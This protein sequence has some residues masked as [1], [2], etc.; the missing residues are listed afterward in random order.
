MSPAL[1]LAFLYGGFTLSSPSAERGGSFPSSSSQ[2][3]KDASHWPG[4]GRM[5]PTQSQLLWHKGMDCSD[6]PGLLTCLSQQLWAEGSLSE[7]HG[8]NV[9]SLLLEGSQVGW[10]KET[11]WLVGAK[12]IGARHTAVCSQVLPE[13][14]E[15]R[16]TF[17]ASRESREKR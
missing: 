3:S 7:P 16:G 13:C 9:G 10:Q 6:W 15:L 11:E 14:L 2:S 1:G 4:L 8:P 17:R 5:V 12:S